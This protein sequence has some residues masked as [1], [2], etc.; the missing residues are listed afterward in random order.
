MI[1]II[2]KTNNENYAKYKTDISSVAE[3]NKIELSWID[4]ETLNETDLKYLEYMYNIKNI[5]DFYGIITS[6]ASK[7]SD[8]VGIKTI[9]EIENILKRK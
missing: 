6:N 9:Q 1:T 8:I 5:N 3:N 2:G 4:Y 7:I